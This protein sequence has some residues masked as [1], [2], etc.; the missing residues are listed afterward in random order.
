MTRHGVTILLSRLFAC[1]I[2]CRVC[3]TLV[4]TNTDPRFNSRRFPV[5]AVFPKR[6]QL[7]LRRNLGGAFGILVA[8][9]LHRRF[10]IP[11]FRRRLTE[12]GAGHPVLAQVFG[13]ATFSVTFQVRCRVHRP[14]RSRGITTRVIRTR[15]RTISTSCFPRIRSTCPFPFFLL[16]AFSLLLRLPANL[17]LRVILGNDRHAG[18]HFDQ[19][20]TPRPNRG[21]AP[22]PTPRGRRQWRTQKSHGR[23]DRSVS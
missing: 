12:T 19:R 5:T 22:K 21:K 14:G 4:A 2:T 7:A 23:Y 18:Q 10:G 8:F 20:W 3:A 17:P 6:V 15:T 16:L 13:V 9:Q 1:V 11:A